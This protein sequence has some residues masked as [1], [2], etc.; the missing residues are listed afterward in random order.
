MIDSLLADMA[1][2]A[3]MSEIV[4]FLIVGAMF[5]TLYFTNHWFNQ[6]NKVLDRKKK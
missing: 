3:L 4:P 6:I 1:K 2:D 5:G